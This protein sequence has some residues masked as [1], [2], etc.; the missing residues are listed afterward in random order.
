LARGVRTNPV[1]SIYSG[2]N[3]G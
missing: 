1:V 2:G 3:Q